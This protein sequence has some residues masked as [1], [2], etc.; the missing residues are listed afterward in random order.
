MLFPRAA[1]KYLKYKDGK[2][3]DDLRYKCL[4]Q[5]ERLREDTPGYPEERE[6]ETMDEIDFCCFLCHCHED[7]KRHHALS[8]TVR[9]EFEL[10]DFG[11]WISKH[12]RKCCHNI[13]PEQQ[14][15][16]SPVGQAL[17][18][19]LENIQPVELNMRQK[20]MLV[21]RDTDWISKR[22][23]SAQRAETQ[24]LN[25]QE[26]IEPKCLRILDERSLQMHSDFTKHKKEC[27][28]HPENKRDANVLDV[29]SGIGCGIVAL[30][31]IGISIDRVFHVDHHKAARFVYSYNHV[32]GFGGGAPDDGIEHI[33]GLCTDFQELKDNLKEVVKKYG[34]FD[35]ILGGPPCNEWSGINARRKGV[36]SESGS[37]ILQFAKLINKVK[38]YNQKYHDV[39]H[40]TYFFCENVP[41]VGKVSE[42]ENTFGISAFKVDAKTWGPCFRERAFFF[43]WEPNTVPEVDSVAKGTSCLKDGWKMPVN[44]TTRGIDEKA[45]TLLASYGR[46]GDPSTMYKARVKEGVDVASKYAPGADIGAEDLEYN[47]FETGDRERLMGLPEGYVEK[48]VIDLFSK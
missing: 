8:E 17:K 15:F 19:P 32:H 41:E 45:R 47:L 31:R 33:C 24:E 38:K 6:S 42:I 14:E 16:I 35:I 43:N 18:A 29:F 5:K 10:P 48:P 30:K 9:D 25:E 40:R 39:N 37:L 4:Q 3:I 28:Q 46:I 1:L 26:E 23:K 11:L 27:L 36:D 22:M 7:R 12:H 44:A 20:L 2:C 34:P 13:I 21:R